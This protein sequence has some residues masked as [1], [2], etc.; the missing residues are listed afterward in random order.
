MPHN[1]AFGSL[2]R[3]M[4]VNEQMSGADA[5]GLEGRGDQSFEKPIVIAG[6]QAHARKLGEKVLQFRLDLGQRQGAMNDVTQKEEFRRPV[7]IAEILQA[8]HRV[9]GRMQ[10]EHLAGVT[11]R[12]VVADVQIGYRKNG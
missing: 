12:P 11:M 2:G 8:V 6:D 4:A 1:D 9:I 7:E 3:Q 10:R 5:F